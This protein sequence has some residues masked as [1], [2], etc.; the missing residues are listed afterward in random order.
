VG[1]GAAAVF[2]L[3][4]LYA[5]VRTTPGRYVDRELGF[6]LS[7]PA[8]W[9]ATA[10]DRDGAHEVVLAPGA[11][12]R[13]V[14]GARCSL[15]VTPTHR[16]PGMTQARLDALMS[17]RAMDA[18]DWAA[19][20]DTGTDDR[21][22]V[23]ETQ[24]RKLFGHPAQYAHVE[25]AMVRDGVRFPVREDRYL[26]HTPAWTWELTCA[27]ERRAGSDPYVEGGELAPVKQI[28]GSLQLLP[29]RPR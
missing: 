23:V 6:A 1:A 21:P 4:A 7:Y 15:T 18:L 29:G 3:G 14:P 24:V 17:A 28:A 2:A 22:V 27:I 10:H 20:V 19:I 25:R 16:E 26:S 5:L 11:L 13:S 12:D 8:D 9:S